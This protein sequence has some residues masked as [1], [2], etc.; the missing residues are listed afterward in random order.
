MATKTVLVHPVDL[1]HRVYILI[2]LSTVT[3]LNQPIIVLP[4]LLIFF[5]FLTPKQKER[6]E[7]KIK[8]KEV[9]GEDLRLDYRLLMHD[10]IKNGENYI[11]IA[12]AFYPDY[13]YNN[14]S[15]FEDL[16]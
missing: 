11:I 10:I 4:S 6:Q 3:L 9:K 14:F 5:N 12:E 7:K 8:D 15:P 13:K 1:V 16:C 2:H